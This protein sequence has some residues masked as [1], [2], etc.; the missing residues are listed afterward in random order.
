L[1][2]LGPL[3]PTLAGAIPLWNHPREQCRQ[4]HSSAHG[5]PHRFIA[6]AD[7][8]GSRGRSGSAS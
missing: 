2:L 3:T 6:G 5:V 8:I 7:A 4:I 1:R